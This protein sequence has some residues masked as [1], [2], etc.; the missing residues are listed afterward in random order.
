M[1]RLFQ[2]YLEAKFL[3]KGPKKKKLKNN[4]SFRIIIGRALLRV[5]KSRYNWLNLKKK[6]K[7]T[8]KDIYFFKYLTTPYIDF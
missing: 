8:K 4:V 3:Q 2:R 1:P 5:V 6:Y 7:I